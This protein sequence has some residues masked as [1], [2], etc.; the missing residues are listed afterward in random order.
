[1]AKFSLEI[2]KESPLHEKLL[3]RLSSR[4]NMAMRGR[5]ERKEKWRRAEELTLAFVPEGEVD[6]TRRMRRE[7]FGVPAYTT[8]QVPYSFAVLMS[9]HTYWTSVFFARSPIHQYSGRHGE[10]EMQVQAME[11]LIGY[12]TEV[13]A[14]V[15]PYY[16]WL[17][18]A[19]KYG[20]G[21]L[22][23][24][25][26]REKLHYGQLVEMPDPNTGE[27]AIY[28]TT[29]EME[30]YVG[31]RVY[32]VSPWDFM[33][34]PRVALKDFQTGEFCCVRRRIGWNYILRRRDQGYFNK[35]TEL[36]RDHVPDKSLGGQQ[37]ASDVLIRPQWTMS[38]Y[39]DIGEE[40]KHP[41]GGDFWEIYVDLVPSEW[42]VGATNFP[43]KWCFTM[44][45]DQGLIVGAQPIG[46]MHCKFPFDILESEVEG[47]G[48]YARGMPEIMEPIQNTMDWLIN[49]HFFNVR[50][51]M[52]NQFIVDPSKLVVKDVQNSG[53]GFV[54]RLRPEAYGTDLSKMFLQVP[55][56]DVTRGHM[57]DF[58]SMFG[59]G[60]K[61][62]G[63]NDQIMGALSQGGRKTATEVR[64][65]TGFG[66]NRMKTVTEYMSATGFSPH[67]QK[68]VQTSQQYYDARAKLR[69]V[70]SFALDAGEQFLN[71]S[72]ED[73]VGF[74]DFVPVD[75]VLPIDRMA[76]ANL[77]K[78]IF[79]QIRM[80]P[81]SVAMGYDWGRIFAWAAELGGLK[82]I[83]QFKVEVR[84]DAMLAAQAQQGNV[85]PLAP[86]K[87]GAR[88]P[89]AGAGNA[90]R[91]ATGFDSMVPP[92]VQLP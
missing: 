17:Y 26:D 70:G 34:D 46:Y 52:N 38:L 62:L 71:V 56:Q 21:I 35:N 77:W 22:G 14:H 87:G 37:E 66:V 86:P 63:V 74:Y 1:M 2:P 60:E 92:G 69:R 58:Q 23:H 19:G 27:P 39:S 65:S 64:T 85:V 51:A 3:K 81:P 30:G 9:A 6:A 20:C 13:G 67:S 83:N 8:I 76:Q 75:G 43:Q 84:P 90:T 68:L 28:Q 89:G 32:N 41:A 50:A 47:Y 48:L 73:I 91:T 42:G 40:S 78:E 18:D 54:W 29:M 7:N 16:I 15:G 61:T 45:T 11:A 53:P 12:Q 59:I 57:T 36:L 31:N 10:G 5:E 79:A 4:V 55:V 82:N 49:T 72:P 33:H 25:W 44:T 24:Y 80:M 88:A